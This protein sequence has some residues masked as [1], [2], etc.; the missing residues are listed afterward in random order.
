MFP[1]IIALHVY[2]NLYYYGLIVLK[3][4]NCFSF[5]GTSILPS[6]KSMYYYMY[7]QH[8]QAKHW[9][10]SGGDFQTP[11]TIKTN[12]DFKCYNAITK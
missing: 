9:L 6:F 3:K 11:G 4:Y 1:Y 7:N 5:Q 10:I 8:R 2:I 12:D